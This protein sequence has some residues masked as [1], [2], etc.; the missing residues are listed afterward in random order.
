MKNKMANNTS[1]LVAA[2]TKSNTNF[3]WSDDLVEDLLKA[4]R[5]FKKVMEFHNKDFSADKPRQYKGVRKE[6]AKINEGY[7]DILE[8]FPCFC[9]LAIWMIL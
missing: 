3:K 1:G 4:L 9:F 2:G 8:Q 5:N 6:I 7:V